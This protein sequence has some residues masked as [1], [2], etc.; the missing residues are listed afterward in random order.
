MPLSPID[1]LR[2]RTRINTQSSRGGHQK[3]SPPPHPHELT[4][5][6]KKTA[7][8]LRP[9]FDTLIR[10]GSP[11][12]APASHALARSPPSRSPPPPRD[13]TTRPVLPAI[14]SR[15]NA[16]SPL[17]E[18]SQNIALQIFTL[19]IP[20]SIYCSKWARSRV[21]SQGMPQD[22]PPNTDHTSRSLLKNYH[23]PICEQGRR[24]SEAA[25]RS[26]SFCINDEGAATPVRPPSRKRRVVAWQRTIGRAKFLSEN[27]I[28]KALQV[29]TLPVDLITTQERKTL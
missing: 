14:H 10:L 28:D 17:H 5:F 7:P 4:P 1:F 6:L 27:T 3:W 23:H 12:P 13:I 18:V 8:R 24:D 15:Q 9:R 11:L 26:I 2:A 19:G 21:P 29:P 16:Q 20:I 22:R 25:R